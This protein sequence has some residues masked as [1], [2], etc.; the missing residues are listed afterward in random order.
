MP[1]GHPVRSRPE[2]ERGLPGSP[3][4]PGSVR[5][6]GC[7]PSAAAGPSHDPSH[8]RWNWRRDR[9]DTRP[10]MAPCHT[11]PPQAGY[12]GVRG[13]RG[14]RHRSAAPVLQLKR[15]S[16]P[17]T[18]T[19]VQGQAAEGPGRRQTHYK[20]HPVAG[21]RW[22]PPRSQQ[23]GGGGSRGQGEDAP[24]HPLCP[25]GD[26]GAGLDHRGPAARAN[27]R[28]SPQAEGCLGDAGRLAAAAH[29]VTGP[30]PA[31]S[32]PACCQGWGGNPTQQ[33]WEIAVG[34]SG[35]NSFTHWPRAPSSASPAATTICAR[36]AARWP[37]ARLAD[38]VARRGAKC[39][40]A[41]LRRGRPGSARVDRGC[42]AAM[43]ASSR[44]PAAA[45]R[46][47]LL[48][49]GGGGRSMEIP[50]PTTRSPETAGIT[51]VQTRSPTPPRPMGK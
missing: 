35:V 27:S 36:S 31:F 1:G 5:L 26:E 14:D 4:A 25:V 6:R 13:S 11:E 28:M 38:R 30:R 43:T 20:I 7:I 51:W 22:A 39:R 8:L 34:G 32:G 16:R 3:R 49:L 21:R 33:G 46:G 41:V 17:H 24:T 10:G 9:A 47:H 23:S 29:P 50:S 45:D 42:G 2:G 44:G 40:R 19:R 48:R 18:C 37:M 12:I 15:K